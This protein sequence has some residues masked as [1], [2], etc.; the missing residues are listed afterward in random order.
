[1]ALWFDLVLSAEEPQ[2]TLSTAPG[3][4]PDCCW[5]QAVYPLAGVPL[6]ATDTVTARFALSKDHISLSSCD[7]GEQVTSHLRLP[8]HV[9]TEMNDEGVAQAYSDIGSRM[10]GHGLFVTT[11]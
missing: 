11:V 5:D 2:I 6:E 9:I 8:R 1:M 10:T 7:K 3:A 4:Y